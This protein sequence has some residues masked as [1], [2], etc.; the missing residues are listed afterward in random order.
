MSYHLYEHES[1]HPF[2]LPDGRKLN[3][4]LYADDLIILL[5]T[6]T[7]L[8]NAIDLLSEF[9]NSWKL[10]VNLKKLK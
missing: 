6:A 10:A 2:I 1:V 9:C 7:G 5:Q 4:L 8:Q 3:S